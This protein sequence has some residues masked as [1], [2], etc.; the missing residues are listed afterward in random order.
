MS[1]I[2]NLSIWCVSHIYNTHTHT[3][4]VWALKQK[5]KKSIIEKS[6]SLGLTFEN[7]LVHQTPGNLKR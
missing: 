5:K 3:L 7:Q 1:S 6:Q 4:F 2:K